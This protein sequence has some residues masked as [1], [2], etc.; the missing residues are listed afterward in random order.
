[1][2][3]NPVWDCFYQAG[4]LAPEAADPVRQQT[5]RRFLGFVPVSPDGSTYRYDARRGEVVSERHGSQ[6]RP[7]LHDQ[8][9]ATSEL[10]KFLDQVRSLRTSFASWTTACTPS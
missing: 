8:V 3:N 10:G 7:D 2:L 5:A 4:L 6:R 9:A 1:M